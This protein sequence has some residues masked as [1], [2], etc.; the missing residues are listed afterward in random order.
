M[1]EEIKREDNRQ[2]LRCLY[3]DLLKNATAEQKEKALIAVTAFLLGTADRK[4]A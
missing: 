4:P 2:D 1:K 3:N